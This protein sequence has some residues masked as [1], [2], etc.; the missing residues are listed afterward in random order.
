VSTIPAANLLP[1]LVIKIKLCES[2]RNLPMPSLYILALC[3]VKSR[4]AFQTG[5]RRLKLFQEQKKFLPC[6]AEFSAKF[7][8]NNPV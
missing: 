8:V 1:V 2:R 5:C 7:Y 6:G 4:D 3:P